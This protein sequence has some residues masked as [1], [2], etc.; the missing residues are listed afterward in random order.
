MDIDFARRERAAAGGRGLAAGW[1]HRSGSHRTVAGLVVLLVLS[2]GSSAMAQGRRVAL[3]VG[4]DAYQAQSVLANAVNDARA[5]A[6]ALEGVGFAVTKVEDANRAQLTSALSDFAGSLRDDDVALFYFAGHGVQVEQENYLIPT[7]Y[8]GQTSSALRFN[9]VSAVD[10]E[11]MLRPARVAMLVFDAC[12]NN[13]YR[14]VRGGAGLAPMEARGT[15]IAYAAG[16][17]E[18]AADAVQG[19]RTVCSRRSSSRCWGSPG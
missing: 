16:A 7:D 1:P 3:V 17:G 13:P 18:F 4:N 8:A 5:V 6:S 19:S 12:R 9:A 10:I 15:L 2:V 11:D 14:G